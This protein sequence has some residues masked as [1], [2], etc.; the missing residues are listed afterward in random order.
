[1]RARVNKL[2]IQAR[3][4][5][6]MRYPYNHSKVYKVIDRIKLLIRSLESLDYNYFIRNAPPGD[7]FTDRSRPPPRNVDNR[8]KRIRRVWR[9]YP[10]KV[11]DHCKQL[12]G[13]FIENRD[14]S[15]EYLDNMRDELYRD[16]GNWTLRNIYEDFYHYTVMQE[17]FKRN[18]KWRMQDA[19]K[20]ELLF[21]LENEIMLRKSQGWYMIFNTLTVDRDHYGSVF[22]AGS[23]AWNDYIRRVERAIGIEIYGTARQAQQEKSTNPYHKYFAVVEEGGESGRLHIHCLHFMRELPPGWYDPNISKEIP[24]DELLYCMRQYWPYG[25]SEPKMVRFNR[26]D[27]YGKLRFRWPSIKDGLN[28]VPRQ[29]Q[30]AQGLVIYMGKYMAKQL[31]APKGKDDYIWRVR[32]SR[33]LGLL[34]MTMLTKRLSDS[35]LE[36]VMLMRGNKKMLMF[37]RRIPLHLLKMLSVKE[38]LTRKSFYAPEDVWEM[39]CA[40]P[41]RENLL[42]QFR[43]LI[44]EGGTS[45]MRNCGIFKMMRLLYMEGSSILEKVRQ[46]ELEC[47]MLYKQFSGMKGSGK[48]YDY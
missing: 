43:D 35:Q 37:N 31:L 39:L 41:P 13:D 45:K 16:P 34:P 11:E 20:K 40:L 14:R 47:G 3:L 42:K 33:K 46:V 26:D 17:R 27:A 18:V 44:R 21:R 1:M 36:A 15:R 30:D 4:F 29:I 48:S 32:L 23:A 6:F 22:S 28:Y 12:F 5:D 9:R 24:C 8:Y 19:R 7:L 2:T 38:W 25:S 10:D